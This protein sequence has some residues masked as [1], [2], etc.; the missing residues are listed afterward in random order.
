MN[1]FISSLKFLIFPLVFFLGMAKGVSAQKFT[2]VFDAKTLPA[3]KAMTKTLLD[4]CAKCDRHR[5]TKSKKYRKENCTEFEDFCKQSKEISKDG[6]GMLILGIS[7]TVSV[8]E[9]KFLSFN[10]VNTS[11]HLYNLRPQIEIF[12]QSKEVVFSNGSKLVDIYL[13]DEKGAYKKKLEDLFH[14]KLKRRERAVFVTELNIGKNHIEGPAIIKINF[15][16]KEIVNEKGEK[17]ERNTVF[18]T[19]TQ[20]IYLKK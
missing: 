14:F 18:K 19:I 4:A 15:V 8:L 13:F 2:K 11:T 7:D 9:S 5:H 1:A 12:D 16:S 6:K 20:D 17:K 10:L 3:S